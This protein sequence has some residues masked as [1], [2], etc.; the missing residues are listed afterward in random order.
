MRLRLSLIMSALVGACAMSEPTQPKV[1]VFFEHDSTALDSAAQAEVAGAAR[2]ADAS[3][4]SLITVAGYAL[5]NGNISADAQL[6]ATRARLV[7][8]LLQRDGVAASRI[9]VIPRDPSNEDAA[10]GA[11]RVEISFGEGASGG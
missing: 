6:A 2:E 10:V 11:R 5:A 1:L 9:E 3:P 4:S 7:A 8:A